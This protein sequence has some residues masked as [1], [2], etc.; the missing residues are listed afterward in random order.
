MTRDTNVKNKVAYRPVEVFPFDKNPQKLG[1]LEKSGA[2][3]R[4]ALD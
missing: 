3:K 2:L 1:E 4:I